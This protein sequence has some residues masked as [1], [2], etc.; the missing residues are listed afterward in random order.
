MFVDVCMS[1]PI[2]QNYPRTVTDCGW[3]GGISL[4]QRSSGQP[5]FGRDLC[6]NPNLPS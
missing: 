6:S 2:G 4:G 5:G 1:E 3:G